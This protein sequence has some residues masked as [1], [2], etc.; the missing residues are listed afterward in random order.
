MPFPG[1]ITP[2][3]P[4]GAP[5]QMLLCSRRSQEISTFLAARAPSLVGSVCFHPP[6]LPSPSEGQ[7][8][9]PVPSKKRNGGS[10]VY[11][12]HGPRCFLLKTGICSSTV[13]WVAPQA[14]PFRCLILHHRAWAGS[15]G[16]SPASMWV[17]CLIVVHLLM[18]AWVPSRDLLKP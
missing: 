5:V 4:F 17:L 15:R 11:C 18:Q 7:R 10:P 6:N 14:L 2:R 3:R 8:R 13:S 9:K 1:S 16:L 12:T